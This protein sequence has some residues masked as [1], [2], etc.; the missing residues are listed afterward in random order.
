M[1]GQQH[2][3][4]EKLTEKKFSLP[5]AQAEVIEETARK[6]S[7]TESQA[8]NYLLARYTKGEWEAL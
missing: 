6:M 7:V 3:T 2:K 5:E 4:V 8:L 1:E